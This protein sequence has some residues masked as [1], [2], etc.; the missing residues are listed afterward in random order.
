MTG[1][2]HDQVSYFT[3]P[4]CPLHCLRLGVERQVPSQIKVPYGL[5]CE[6]PD[7]LPGQS[8]AGRSAAHRHSDK[9]GGKPSSPTSQPKSIAERVCSRHR[10]SWEQSRVGL[11]HRCSRRLGQSDSSS[12]GSPSD[13]SPSPRD[14]RRGAMAAPRHSWASVAHLAVLLGHLDRW[15]EGKVRRKTYVCSHFFSCEMRGAC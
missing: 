3:P 9:I 11:P 5:P 1:R 10:R 8:P 14:K 6:V 4:P 2:R 15:F 13:A 7:P 12:G